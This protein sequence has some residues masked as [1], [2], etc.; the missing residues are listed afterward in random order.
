MK[1][2][3]MI[4]GLLLSTLI[5]AQTIGPNSIVLN[6]PVNTGYAPDGGSVLVSD[7]SDTGLIEAGS[8]HCGSGGIH[9]ENSYWRYFDID[10]LG[11]IDVTDVDIGIETAAAGNGVEQPIIFRLYSIP[12]GASLPSATLTLVTEVMTVTG[13]NSAAVANFPITGSLDAATDDLVLEVNLPDG[14]TD[15]NSFFIGSNTSAETNSTYLSAADCG[16]NDPT[17]VG[18]IGFPDMHV[19]MV[20]NGFANVPVELMNFSVE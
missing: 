5:N 9:A 7:P 2:T 20:V 12:N 4:T 1:K 15:N 18:D 17:A 8:V 14:G 3:T 13:D 10:G 19:V 16:I 6:G 11:Q